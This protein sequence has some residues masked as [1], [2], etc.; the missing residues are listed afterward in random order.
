MLRISAPAEISV[1]KI[2]DREWQPVD[3]QRGTIPAHQT[4][5]PLYA[6]RGQMI[7]EP[8]PVERP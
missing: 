1:L 8:L 5:T 2:E 3:S 6:I 4:I 7:Y